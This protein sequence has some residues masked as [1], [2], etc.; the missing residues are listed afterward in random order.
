MSERFA[1]V[2][3]A[4]AVLVI[5]I[6]VASKFVLGLTGATWVDPTLVLAVIAL[7]VLIPRWGDFLIGDLRLVVAGAAL[8]CFLS[9]ACAIS[10]AL[11]RPPSSL[12]DVLREPLRLWLNLVW[13][14]LSCWFLIYRPRVVLIASLFAVAFGLASGLY[15]HLVAFGRAPASAS[16]VSYT[17]AYL[18]RQTLWVNGF[19]IPRMGGLFFESPPFGLFMLSMLVVIVSTR[20]L[21]RVKWTTSAVVCAVIGLVCSLADQVLLAGGIGLLCWMP[22]LGRRHPRIAWPLALIATTVLCVFEFQAITVKAGSSESGI[23][24]RINGSSVGE[25]S[26]HVHYGLALLQ[27]HPMATLFGIGPGRYG[28]YAGDTGDFPETVNMQTSEME[29]LVEWGVLGLA[30]W[31]AL[32]GGLAVRICGERGVLGLGLF[33]AIIVAD[34][35]QAN[36]KHE[37]VFLAIAAL[38]IPFFSVPAGLESLQCTRNQYPGC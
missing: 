18:L 23:V 4:I 8:V 27:S 7:L 11:I 36:W 35:F 9:I 12:Y 1:T 5:P 20:T 37:A 21:E 13:L 17:R 25:R 6:N 34:S 14:V 26:F 38:C 28:E 33:V 22:S 3:Y 15:F 24:S 29:L 32:I 2:L 31:V 30:V 19:P 10:G 16:V